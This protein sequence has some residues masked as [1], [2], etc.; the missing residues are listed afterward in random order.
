MPSPN[1]D[2][3]YDV[4]DYVQGTR[5]EIAEHPGVQADVAQ[6]SAQAFRDM[7][8]AVLVGSEAQHSVEAPRPEGEVGGRGQQHHQHGDRLHQGHLW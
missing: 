8:E 7:V 5:I 2:W 4:A 1:A 6:D 3:G